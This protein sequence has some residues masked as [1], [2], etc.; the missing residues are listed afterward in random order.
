MHQVTKHQ[1]CSLCDLFGDHR[2]QVEKGQEFQ[3][4][5]YEKY[6]WFILSTYFDI[7]I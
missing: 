2:V 4:N 7:M 6:A 5:F 1:S 3:N